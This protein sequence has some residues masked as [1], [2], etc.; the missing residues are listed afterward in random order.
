[1]PIHSGFRPSERFAPLAAR[2]PP[3]PETAKDARVPATGAGFADV[4]VAVLPSVILTVAG[5]P[6]ADWPAAG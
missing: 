5:K 6:L 4:T 2:D 1:M 3:V